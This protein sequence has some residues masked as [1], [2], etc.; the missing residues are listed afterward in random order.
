MPGV[1]RIALLGSVAT[2]KPR[3]KDIDLLVAVTDDMDLTALATAGRRLKG[4]AQ[5]ANL[6]ADVF[7]ADPAGRYLG[8]TCRWTRCI[9]GLRMR[10]EALTCGRRQYLYDDLKVLRL[11]R[12]TITA[13]P[14]ELHP[15]IVTRVPVPADVIKF[16]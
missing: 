12:A 10:C 4:H 3:P 2:A 5:Q 15:R 7:L 16:L 1:V 13:P 8:R 9:P 11:A 14:I 6:G